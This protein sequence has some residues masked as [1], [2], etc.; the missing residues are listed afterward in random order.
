MNLRNDGRAFAY[1][2]GDP[3]RRLGAYVADGEY[4]V[5][6]RL[7]GQRTDDPIAD[8]RPSQHEAPAVKGNT[9]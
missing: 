6:V 5:N 3:F 1:G 4:A 8:I 2:R 9:A 7:Q